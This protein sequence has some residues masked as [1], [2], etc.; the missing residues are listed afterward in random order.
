MHPTVSARTDSKETYPALNTAIT[1]MLL[2][3]HFHGADAALSKIDDDTDNV[4]DAFC[5]QARM[6]GWKSF[7][8]GIMSVR[9]VRIQQKWYDNM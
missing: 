1:S 9:W 2:S 7:M 8:E 5:A 3:W 4:L 6:V